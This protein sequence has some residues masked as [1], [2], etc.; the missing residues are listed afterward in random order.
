MTERRPKL[1]SYAGIENY[2]LME[3][4]HDAFAKVDSKS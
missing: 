4:K 2:F 1:H 3:G